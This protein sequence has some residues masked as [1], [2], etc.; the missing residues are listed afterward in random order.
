MP[1]D[2]NFL[3]CL[4][5]AMTGIFFSVIFYNNP[6]HDYG[7]YYFGSKFALEGIPVDDIYEPWKFNVLIR[8]LPGMSMEHFFENYAVVPPFT[9][10]FYMPFTILD[11]HTS[12]LVF[13]L[14]S[15][16]IFCYGLLKL[17]RHLD[18]RSPFVLMLPV[19]LLIPFRNNILFG[20]TYLLIMGLMMAGF[21][22]EEKK[23]NFAAAI[24]YSLSIVLKISP[25]ILILY[26]LARKN[27]RTA[28]YT[29]LVSAAFFLSAVYFTG[30]SFMME[31]TFSYLPRMSINE[32][33]NP[34]ATT[35][36]SVTVLLRNLFIPD[37]LL[38]PSAPFK[39]LAAYIFYLGIITGILF[40]IFGKFVLK[41][42]NRFSAFA[43]TLLAGFVLTAYTSSYSLIFLLPLCVE[44]VRMG[45]RKG[46]IVLALAG[47]ACFIPMGWFQSLPLIARFPRL[48]IM[49]LL[50]FAAATPVHSGKKYFNWL[51]LSIVIFTAVTFLSS[52]RETD[53]SSYYI[54]KEI[55]LLSYD[56]SFSGK[57]LLVKVLEDNGP[58]EKII[59][60]NEE[61]FSVEPLQ[62]QNNQ[63]R[64]KGRRF[65]GS[66]N[67]L[68]AVVVN[69]RDIVYLS[70]RNRGIGFYALRKIS[71][72]P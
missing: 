27:F 68:K 10:F 20:Q 57:N 58:A 31:Y 32:I 28:C 14:I 39:S 19:L 6:I 15:V 47:L 66:D 40:F 37:Q 54:G 29:I 45:G 26:L 21:V 64:F 72:G 38:N 7:N 9:L 17:F 24:F 5:F 13:N 70:D 62:I 1:K 18:I 22:A 71:I 52:K 48:F 33:N 53:E 42:A 3:C 50:F 35:Y 60:F 44:A 23:K 25:A 12:K 16:L 36:Q 30:W 11:V 8:Q 63:I 34:Y 67:K 51:A 65:A 56:F 61:I 69:G 49:L 46:L 2:K 55:S 43:F 59:P 41:T 4:L